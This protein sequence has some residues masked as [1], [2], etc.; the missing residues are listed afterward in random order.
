M[1]QVPVGETETDIFL[2]YMRRNGEDVAVFEFGTTR[3]T[4][5]RAECRDRLHCLRLD[6]LPYGQ[7]SEALCRWPLANDHN[8]SPPAV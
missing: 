8:V 2:G 3:Y 6:G 1:P 4:L 5:T 7:A